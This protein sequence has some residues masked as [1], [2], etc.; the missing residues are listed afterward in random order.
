MRTMRSIYHTFILALGV[1][2]LTGC[3]NF[4][5]VM[6]DNRT[7]V[8]DEVKVKDL[9]VSA[10]PTHTYQIFTE[11]MS[12]NVDEYPNTYTD[13][14]VDEFYAWKDPTE[15]NNESPEN[16]WQNAYNAITT[17]NNALD[18][19]DKLGGPTT[20]LLR[21]SMGE[22]LMVRAYGHFMLVN[23]FCKNY[24]A[25]TSDKD[26]GI[27]LMYETGSLIGQVPDRGTVADVYKSID[28]DIQKALPLVGD[29]HLSVP[30]YHFNVGA[31]YAFAARFYLYYEK[32]DKAIEYA[33]KCLGGNPASLLRDWANAAKLPSKFD[34][35]S[36]HYVSSELNCNLLLATGFSKGGLAFGPYRT[37]KKYT[38]GTYISTNELGGAQNIWGSSTRLYDAP[39][40]YPGTGYSYVIYW[41]VP[42]LF[43]YT[44]PVAGIGY[45]KSIFTLLTTD[46]CLLN[47]AEAYIMTKKFDQAAADLTLWMQNATKSKMVLTPKEIEE[48][49]NKAKY[50]YDDKESPLASTIK[51]HLHPAFT[52]DK[53]GSTQEAM[54]QCVLGFRRLETIHQG[55]RWFDIKRYGIEYPRRKISMAGEPEE[56][57]DFLSKDDDRRALQLPSKVIDAGVKPNPRNTTK[58]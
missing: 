57:T 3:D 8:D 32:W 7:I 41:R 24:N 22:A 28:A 1:A 40:T 53:E 25:A 49:Y 12:D 6:P 20:P 30:K 15:N 13:R 18:A 58:K 37:W 11:L 45:N 5:D 23:I 47:R 54:L 19:I 34:V 56:K 26:L 33:N 46:E 14:F 48:F 51:K 55:I 29:S 52:I 2:A 42:Y 27:P 10:Y 39:H 17:A 38:H 35:R 43:E 9:L 44:D 21:E 31:A 36:Q 16:Y 4:L 50:S